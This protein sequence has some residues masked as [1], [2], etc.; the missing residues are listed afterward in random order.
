M[1]CSILNYSVG[2]VEKFYSSKILLTDVLRTYSS[3]SQL[4]SEICCTCIYNNLQTVLRHLHSEFLFIMAVYLSFGKRLFTSFMSTSDI[5][6]DLVNSW[7]F[8]GYNASSQI[9]NAI[10]GNTVNASNDNSSYPINII[11]MNHNSTSCIPNYHINNTYNIS[12]N[13]TI[14]GASTN[15]SMCGS[16]EIGIHV[17]WGSLGIYIMFIPGLMFMVMFTFADTYTYLRM[18]KFKT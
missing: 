17:V 5:V 8:L 16:E 3:L 2:L 7:D 18:K 9:I 15:V 12:L 6:S 13:N 14:T 11:L 4:S 1:D 10:S